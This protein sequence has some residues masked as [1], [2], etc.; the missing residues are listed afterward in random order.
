M[1]AIPQGYFSVEEIA[2]F[3]VKAHEAREDSFYPRG[4]PPSF[5]WYKLDHWAAVEAACVPEPLKAFVYLGVAR[6]EMVD[7]AQG[8][9]R[10]QPVGNFEAP[11]DNWL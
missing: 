8:V 3:I 4:G 6:G 9:L 5:G 1:R 11:D 10:K 7:W 2:G